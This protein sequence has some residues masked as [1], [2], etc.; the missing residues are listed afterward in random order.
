MITERLLFFFTSSSGLNF[1]P[2]AE[3][4]ERLNT[5]YNSLRSDC[6]PRLSLA[7]ILRLLTQT[8]TYAFGP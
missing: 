3:R 1:R 8:G 7:G 6:S 5:M 2:Q 4:L